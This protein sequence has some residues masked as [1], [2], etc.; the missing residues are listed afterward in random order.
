MLDGTVKRAE[1]ALV[2]IETPYVSGKLPCLCT[3]A[4]TCDVI[5]NN[6]QLASNSNNMDEVSAVTT[7][8]KALAEGKPLNQCPYRLLKS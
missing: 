3:D 5:V 1:I 4:P 2:D 7:R 8:A 6:V